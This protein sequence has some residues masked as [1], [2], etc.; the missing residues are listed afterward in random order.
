MNTVKT[1]SKKKNEIICLLAVLFPL[2]KSALALINNNDGLM[3]LYFTVGLI[4]IIYGFFY[5]GNK[6]LYIART[7]GILLFVL[8]STNLWIWI[9]ENNTYARSQCLIFTFCILIWTVSSRK[10]VGVQTKE[11]ILKNERKI[12]LIRFIYYL[13]LI[14]SIIIGIGYDSLHWQTFSLSGPYAASHNLAYEMLLW[15]IID[16]IYILNRKNKYYIYLIIDAGIIV[17]TVARSI[18]IPL[19]IIFYYIF[20]NYNMQKR[21]MAIVLAIL[22]G[23]FLL[24]YTDLFSGLIEKTNRALATSTITSGRG[25]IFKT[26]LQAFWEAP[27]SQKI[28]GMGINGLT[29]Y[30][31]HHIWMEIHA[32]NDFIDALTQYGVIGFITYIYAFYRL[33]HNNGNSY[34]AGFL[35]F[36]LAFVNGYYVSTSAVLGTVIFLAFNSSVIPKRRAVLS[37]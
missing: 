34:I 36:S 20:K 31:L 16:A 26:S 7:D 22:G 8:L 32:H 6:S 17:L 5:Y 23:I 27:I 3:T 15:A 29:E 33:I 2:L 18:L 12:I 30:N 11:W 37:L 25:M 28:M 21:F 1:M 4:V 19:V 24:R 14:T 10:K 35:I 13:I 9:K